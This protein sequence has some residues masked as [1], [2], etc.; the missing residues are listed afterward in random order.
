MPKYT[1]FTTSVESNSYTFTTNESLTI[2]ADA[3]GNYFANSVDIFEGEVVTE[4]FQVN[5]A[6]VDQRFVLSNPEIDT[7]SLSVKISTSSADTSNAEWKSS[8][9]AVG[10][11]GTSNVY[12]IV[13]AEGDK[14]ELQFGDG[15]LGK[16]LIN[17][18]VI[19]ATY[20]KCNANSA[21][22][23]SVFNSAASIQGH[24]NVIVSTC[25]LY[26]SPSPRDS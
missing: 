13:P 18:N 15:V 23:A 10:L 2:T 9:S 3:N 4:L 11:S 6:N 16:A 24:S 20:R 8:L 22:E 1:E 12:Y 14:Y 7:D 17:G 25:L 26:T 21:N 5:T 19:E